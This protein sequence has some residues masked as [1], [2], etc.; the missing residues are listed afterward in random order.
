MRTP[1]SSTPHD[2]GIVHDPVEVLADIRGYMVL[3]RNVMLH[4]MY[5][6]FLEVGMEGINGRLLHK[7]K[8]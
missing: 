2:D 4:K 1:Q 7:W 5:F 8:L 3:L 6:I